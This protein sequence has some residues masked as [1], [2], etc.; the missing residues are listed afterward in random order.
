MR[1]LLIRHGQTPS[2]V[3]RVLDTAAPGPALTPLGESQ[4]AA[5]PAVLASHPIGAVY[6]STLLRTQLTAAPL[7]AALGL[8]VR[9][10]DGIRELDAGELEMRGDGEAIGTYLETVFA[11]S[12]GE[13]DRSMPGGER[14]DEALARFD[15]VVAE[16]A[17]E[18]VTAALFSHG[19]AIRMWLAARAVNVTVDEVAWRELEN[20]GV[21]TVTGSPGQGW[22]LEGWTEA[23]VGETAESGPAGETPQDVPETPAG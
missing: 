19:A 7:A 15:A 11:W 13:T 5:L 6:A 17:A 14:G 4:A 18:G 23:P 2:N 3:R 12:A 8:A 9:V 1:L 21:V 22:S 10:R 16:A 20:A